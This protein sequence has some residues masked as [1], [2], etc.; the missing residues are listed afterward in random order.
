MVTT[1]EHD[2]GSRLAE[3]VTD[4]KTDNRFELTIDG[5]T[6]FLLY[7]RRPQAL[8]LIHTEVPEALRGR[9]LGDALAKAAI[10]VARADGIR[11]VPVCP[12]VQAYLHKHPL[13]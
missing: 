7:E 3:A 6:A 13:E 11:I 12:F 8:A 2:K 5:H 9:H 4:N 10:D 1:T